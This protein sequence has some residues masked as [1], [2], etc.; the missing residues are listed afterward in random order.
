M[1][2]ERFGVS[3]IALRLGVVPEVKLCPD[4]EK[5][6]MLTNRECPCG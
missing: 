6:G 1:T 5:S 3:H 4:E 2:L